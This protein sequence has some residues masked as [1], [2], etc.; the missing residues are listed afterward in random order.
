M[1]PVQFI[2]NV[3][4]DLVPHLSEGDIVIDGGNTKWD[5]DQP[6]ADRLAEKGIHFIDCGV[7]GGVWGLENGYA[8]MCGGD[9]ADVAAVMPIFEALK[10]EGEFGF[11]P[12]RRSRRRALRQ[13]GPQRHG[14]RRSCRRTPR[15]GN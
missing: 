8:L 9:E 12:R 13:D 2:D 4:D 14:V 11:V 10:P 15:A 7:S 1:V 5:G 3:L 6:R